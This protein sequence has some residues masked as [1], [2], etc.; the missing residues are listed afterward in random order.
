MRLTHTL[1]L[2]LLV[3][4]PYNVCGLETDKKSPEDFILNTSTKVLAL[5][6]SKAPTH[7]KQKGLSHIFLEVM[8]V[9]WIGK[10][11]LGHYWQSL[12][13]EEKNTYLNT[14]KQYL[15]YTYVSK[16]KEFNNQKV[17]IKSVKDL[18]N[19][20]YLMATEIEAPDANMKVEYRI[21]E[22]SSGYKIRDIIAE[23]VSLL[24]TERSEFGSALNDKDIYALTE[25][26]RAKI[27]EGE[28]E[29]G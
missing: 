12:N 8:D 13:P 6:N 29:P 24:N 18:G 10:F 3:V 25:Q 2:I 23:G 1:A 27:A 5:L 22:N 9:E 19:G 17:V 28:G 15:A 7:E 11:V 26:L 14:Y 21:K 20:Q 16:L 4:L